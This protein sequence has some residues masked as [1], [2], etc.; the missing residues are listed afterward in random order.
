MAVD[1]TKNPIPFEMAQ[2]PGPEMAKPYQ[3]KVI[4]AILKKA[5]RP[6]LVVGAEL[7]DDPV[8]FDKMI[9]IGKMGVPIAATAH[10]VKGFVDRGYMENVYQIGLHPLTNYL[11][12]DDWMG[13]DGK[14]QYDT[15]IFMGIFYKFANAMFSTLKHFNRNI[16]RVSIDRYYHV[17]ANMTFGNM[18]FNPEDYHAA[19]D[20]VIAAMKK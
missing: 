16:K 12:F 13:L 7:F 5:K 8:M 2:I 18:A 17:N 10:S 20:E 4:G 9:E 14:G 3:A 15:V 1:T 11:R 6:L 19:V